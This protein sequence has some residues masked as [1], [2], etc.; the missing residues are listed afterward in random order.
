MNYEVHATW[1]N[2]GQ[3][4]WLLARN[5]KQQQWRKLGS[6]LSATLFVLHVDYYHMPTTV[7]DFIDSDLLIE[8]EVGIETTSAGL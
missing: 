2:A 5:P 7:W 4:D 8:I 3:L 6:N 1:Q